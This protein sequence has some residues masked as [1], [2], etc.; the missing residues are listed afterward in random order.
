M[1]DDKEKHKFY[2][3]LLRNLGTA[4]LAG[5]YIS[6]ITNQAV[7]DCALIAFN[8][9]VLIGASSL[10]IEGKQHEYRSYIL[11]CTRYRRTCACIVLKTAQAHASYTLTLET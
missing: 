3:E 5:A 7:L 8:G 4:V 6:L 2:A 10:I 11:F 9:F 1:F